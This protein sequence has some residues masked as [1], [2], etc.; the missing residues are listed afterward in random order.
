MRGIYLS[1]FSSYYL[2]KLLLTIYKSYDLQ[3]RLIP[4][5]IPSPDELGF[6]IQGFQ[7]FYSNC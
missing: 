4:V 1:L 3:T 2:E 6:V 5:K 7:L